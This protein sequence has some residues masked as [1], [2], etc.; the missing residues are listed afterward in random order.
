MPRLR[1]LSGEA[2]INLTVPIREEVVPTYLMFS[3]TQSP[4][5]AALGALSG[6]GPGWSRAGTDTAIKGAK[7]QPSWEEDADS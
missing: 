6:C 3:L 2:W 5:V 7:T 1:G 4:L